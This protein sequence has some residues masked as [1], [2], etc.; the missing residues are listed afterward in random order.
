MTK[1]E[2]LNHLNQFHGS[3][4]WTK[5]GPLSPNLLTEGTKFLAE[6]TG[7]YWLFDMINS[8]IDFSDSVKSWP[9][10]I[11]SKLSVDLEKESADL[12]MM[13]GDG[14]TLVTQHVHFTDFPLDDITIWSEKAGHGVK[15]SL[16]VYVHLLPSEH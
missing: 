8:H 10:F 5:M 1:N 11:V 4:S 3:D 16:N 15:A 7:A 13:D 6:N 12:T 14:Q 9:D 2:L